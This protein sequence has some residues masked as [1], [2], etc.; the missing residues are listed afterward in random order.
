MDVFL[1]LFFTNLSLPCTPIT[2]A[3]TAT[4]CVVRCLDTPPCNSVFYHE[5]SQQC[6]PTTEVYT[7]DSSSL[8]PRDGTD[9]FIRP[10]LIPVTPVIKCPPG[11]TL[12]TTEAVC[13]TL[14]TPKQ[15][16]QNADNECTGQSFNGMD[17]RM[18]TFKTEAK[19]EEI[20][21]FLGTD[22]EGVW[23]GLKYKDGDWKWYDGT[24]G[25]FQ[26]WNPNEPNFLDSELCAVIYRP[27]HWTL[28]NNYCYVAWSVMCEVPARI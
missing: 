25:Q 26:P 15:S 13:V 14:T 27:T 18:I 21:Q 9:Y 22:V 1:T 12:F 6:C 19:Y 3:P 16:W 20:K 24:V 11:A 7:Q 5:A 2:T 28:H 8:L 4:W 23:T 17:Y 10:S